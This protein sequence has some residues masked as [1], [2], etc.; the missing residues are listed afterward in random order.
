MKN[1]SYKV[2]KIKTCSNFHEFVSTIKGSKK[3]CFKVLLVIMV[4]INVVDEYMKFI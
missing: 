1:L 3:S 2:V 4:N